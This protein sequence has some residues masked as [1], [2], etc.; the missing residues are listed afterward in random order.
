MTTFQKATIPS[1]VTANLV[2]KNVEL[3]KAFSPTN[4]QVGGTSTVTITITNPKVNALTDVAFTDNLPANL[5]V[6]SGSGGLSTGCTGT[7]DTSVPTRIMLT[8]G[9]IPAGSSCEITAVVTSSV[10]GNYSNTVSC[11]DMSYGGG[12]TPGCEEASAVLTVYATSFG[13]SATKSF[14]PSNIAPGTATTMTI[15]VTAPGDTN[16]TNFS[17]TD[18]LPANVFINNP[19]SATQNSNCGS[20]TITAI[21]GGSTFNF[22]NGTIPAG[23]TC[24]LTV[25]VTSSEYGPHTNTIRRA[26]ISNTENRNIP[27]P[28]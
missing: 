17:L 5:T 4:F 25:A 9:T 23:S 20:G 26:D 27:Q 1:N 12:G 3:D 22:S 16:L 19:P 18:N 6:Q 2:V 15:A 14:S 21:A 28:K 11:S 13:T 24:T 7:V 8:G 10:A